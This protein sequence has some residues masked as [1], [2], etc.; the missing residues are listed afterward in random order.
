MAHLYGHDSA[1]LEL[2]ITT[3]DYNRKDPVFWIEAITKLQ[4]YKH[5]ERRIPRYYSEL[6]RLH[7]HLLATLDD[8]YV[9]ALP[10]CPQPKF[11]R[12]GQLLSRHYRDFGDDEEKLQ[13]LLDAKIQ[14]WLD[15]ITAHDRIQQSEGLREF[16]ESE[17]G[18]RPKL[19]RVSRQK[20]SVPIHRDDL[21][22]EFWH[23]NDQIDLFLQHLGQVRGLWASRGNTSVWAEFGAAWVAYGALERDPE[24]FI[25][26]K[27]IARGCQQVY[28]IEILQELAGM[29]TLGDEIDYQIRNASNAQQIMSRRLSVLSD[30]FTSRK[31]T[32]SCLRNV[33]R[34]K[35]SSMIDR[36]TANDAIAELDQARKLEQQALQRYE[37]IDGNYDRDLEQC[38]KPQV[39][40]DM[41]H[42]I[43]SFAKCQLNLERQKLAT[44]ESVLS[45]MSPKPIS[46]T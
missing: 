22:P 27:N 21:E 18:F 34:L 14:L 9:P 17:I 29:E 15:R 42:A 11:D 2:R 19:K 3:V 24:L 4:K 46:S 16:V 10:P 41:V 1:P 28:Q 37:R 43:R 39:A 45:C 33:E 44:W 32:E 8:V 31:R 5:K 26:Y 30:Y 35:S 25:L 7:D 6:E 36:E 20:K 40:A 13:E 12:Q 38:Y 23:L